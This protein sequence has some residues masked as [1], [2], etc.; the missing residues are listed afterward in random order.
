MIKTKAGDFV[1]VRGRTET[2]PLLWGPLEAAPSGDLC[3]R[4]G[5]D[6]ED[7]GAVYDQ[8]GRAYHYDEGARSGRNPM[9][10]IIRVEPRQGAAP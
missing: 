6:S 3:V 7:I 5:T 4:Y 2:G 9:A 1:I 10:D 8:D